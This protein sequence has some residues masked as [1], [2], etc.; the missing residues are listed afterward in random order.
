MTAT[1]WR[2]LRLLVGGGF[3]QFLAIM[4]L[5]VIARLYETEEIGEY[6]IFASMLM[7]VGVIFSFG[8]NRVILMAD[9]N[10]IGK[11]VNCYLSIIIIVVVFY[12]FFSFL[13][14][15][16]VIN[17]DIVYFY[18]L[19]L[20]IV[21]SLILVFESLMYRFDKFGRQAIAHS[22]F[23]VVNHPV[24]IFFGAF[25]YFKQA[26]LHITLAAYL[27][28]LL[29]VFCFLLKEIRF[30]NIRPNIFGFWND[31]RDVFFSHKDLFLY[32]YPQ[33][34][35]AAFGAHIPVIALGAIYGS[36]VAA[37]VGMAMGVLGAPIMLLG[38]SIY[39]VLQKRYSS[40]IGALTYDVF[41]EYKISLL[42]LILI[43]VFGV[44]F[45][46]FFGAS[47]IKYIFGGEWVGLYEYIFIMSLWFVSMLIAKPAMALVSS[48]DWDRYLLVLE[49]AFFFIRIFA[50]VI[51]HIY[52][53][54][55]LFAVFIFSVLSA[56]FYWVVI[57]VVYFII[58][59]GKYENITS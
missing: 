36:V 18:A 42:I 34:V 38:N 8:F 4:S 11:V 43:S 17:F 21:F 31:G 30:L 49:V 13:I 55:P 28:K 40:T 9:N 20:G 44:S 16:D 19:G 12:L 29:I 32:R 26:L 15:L 24:K 35:M 5:P 27:F 25:F 46:Y 23:S 39:N 33:T 45:F 59:K 1:V 57:F 10:I 48:L 14:F 6:N 2:M 53:F 56:I 41:G 47:L 51:F 22:F 54:E 52:S 58:R 3:S 37:Y 7:L 50:L